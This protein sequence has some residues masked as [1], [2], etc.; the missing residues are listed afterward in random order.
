MRWEEVFRNT[1]FVDVYGAYPHG[2]I[3]P[4]LPVVL[5]VSQRADG[6]GLVDRAIKRLQINQDLAPT[7]LQSVP[8][9]EPIIHREADVDEHRELVGHFIP[10]VPQHAGFPV[11][12]PCFMDRDRVRDLAGHLRHAL[13][14]GRPTLV[15]Q[16]R[17]VVG[18]VQSIDRGGKHRALRELR[19]KTNL[20]PD[21]L[22]LDLHVA[23]F[24]AR[25]S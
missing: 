20:E 11:I 22:R 17:I 10:G 4:L 23:P 18:R 8:V 16:S 15:R 6:I 3:R 2:H 21:P 1:I 14:R 12:D 19:T 7:G 24:G 5:N 25:R 13:L 9:R